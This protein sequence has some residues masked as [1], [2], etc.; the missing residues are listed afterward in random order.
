MW[1]E[2]KPGTAPPAALLRVVDSNNADTN[3][4]KIEID[5][6]DKNDAERSSSRRSSRIQ[7]KRGAMKFGDVLSQAAKSYLEK[8]D[9][10]GEGG[11]DE[12]ADSDLNESEYDDDFELS[13]DEKFSIYTRYRPP[14]IRERNPRNRPM[15]FVDKK[16]KSVQ[17]S[18]LELMK[19]KEA[20]IKKRLDDRIEKRKENAERQRL[21][22]LQT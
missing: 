20:L 1:S 17:E 9:E 15:S 2:Y 7:S 13:D 10:N 5:P 19:Q 12:D 11:K 14:P 18:R 4:R 3:E 6:D 8:L 22:A 16:I 21:Q